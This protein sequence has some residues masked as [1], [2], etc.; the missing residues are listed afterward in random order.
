MDK[1]NKKRIIYVIIAI[2]ILI[3]CIIGGLFLVNSKEDKEPELSEIVSNKLNAYHTDISD[4]LDSLNSDEAVS[5]YLMNWAKNKKIDASKDT[6]GNVIYTKKASEGY[7]NVPPVVIVCGYD[8]SNMQ[9]Y[10]EPVAIAL[11]AAKNTVN[12]GTFRIIFTPEKSA[13]DSGSKLLSDKNF[14][15]DTSLFYLGKSGSSTVTATTG[16]YYTF[17][18]SDKLDY[19]KPEFDK[20]YRISIDGLPSKIARSRINSSPNAVKQLGDLLANLKSTSLLFEL[21]MF[22]GGNEVNSIPDSA[23]MKILISSSDEEKFLSRIEAAK[24]RFTEKYSEDFPEAVFSCEEVKLPTKVISKE[25]TDKLVSLLY[26]APNGVYEK[27]DDGNVTSISNIGYV[28]T[29][30]DRLTINVSVSG[31]DQAAIDELKESYTI[32]SGLS[33]VDYKCTAEYP[34]FSESEYNAELT[35]KFESAFG[36]Y[37]DGSNMKKENAVEF[38]PLTFL[39]EKND[40]MQ[41]LYLGVTDRTQEKIAGALITFLDNSNDEKN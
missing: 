14:T 27:D 28:S 38:T 35:G 6:G 13:E 22:N 12:S 8:S 40:K 7:E 3:A 18:L 15:D 37:T 9:E 34:V 41:M 25:K 16:G 26:T 33:E 5:D 2:L 19:S 4:S 32:I 20:A 30:D 11:T 31:C 21:S 36:R 1:I 29:K 23:S 17:E 24:N 10:I 39:R